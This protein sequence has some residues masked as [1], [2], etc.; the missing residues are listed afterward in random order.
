M[1]R[2]LTSRP[3]VM[4]LALLFFSSSSA[5]A[6]EPDPFPSLDLRGYRPSTD[7]GATLFLEPAAAPAH[8]DYNL[9]F[10]LSYVRSPI[11]LRKLV[12]REEAYRPITDQLTGDLV[13]GVGAWG[14][15]SFGLDLPFALYQVGDAPTYDSI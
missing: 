9:G 4:A 1:S 14:R 6:V 13:A 3:S 2:F 7:P 5:L 12:G 11:V 15:A 10:S 8:G